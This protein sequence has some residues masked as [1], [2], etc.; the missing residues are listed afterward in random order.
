MAYT[1][2]GVIVILFNAVLVAVNLYSNVVL[3]FFSSFLGVLYLFFLYMLVSGK[4]GAG[5]RNTQAP[6]NRALVEL[7]EKLTPGY[8]AEDY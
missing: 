6:Q 3:A 5:Q 1:T 4:F 7:T 8:L 2:I